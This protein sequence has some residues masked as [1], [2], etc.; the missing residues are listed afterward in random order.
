MPFNAE[1]RNL[2]SIYSCSFPCWRTVHSSIDRTSTNSEKLS[3][4][5][6]TAAKDIGRLLDQMA[7][8]VLRLAPKSPWNP[9]Y[10][11]TFNDPEDRRCHHT[12]GGYALMPYV[13]K[14]T[15]QQAPWRKRPQNPDHHSQDTRGY[16]DLLPNSA[17]HSPEGWPR[18]G[19]CW[20][21]VKLTHQMVVK[22]NG[23][24]LIWFV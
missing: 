14:N 18:W 1:W 10:E 19:G 16:V 20:G 11:D 7:E 15:H 23:C 17:G 5:I 6:Q 12:S 2:R 13:K 4:G 24:H 3:K 22:I 8:G 9:S 21:N